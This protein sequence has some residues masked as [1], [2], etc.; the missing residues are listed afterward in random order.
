M[1]AKELKQK[2]LDFFRSKGHAIIPASSLIPENDPTALFINSGMHPLVPFLLGEKHPSGKRL[3]NFQKC[4]RTG[5]I[6]DV[7]DN[8]HLTFFEMLGNWSLGDYFKK[9][10]IA[11]SFEFLTSREWLNIPLERLVFTVFAGDNDVPRDEEAASVWRSLG[12]KDSQI[13]YLGREDNWWGPAGQTGPCGPDTEMF[14]DRGKPACSPSCGPGCSCGKYVEIWNDVFMQYYKKAD[15]AYEP[16]TQKNID[17]GMGVERTAAMLSGKE[18]VYEIDEFQEI[19]R[20]IEK[21]SGKLYLNHAR[22]F[23]IIADHLR[24]SVFI[25]GDQRGVVPSNV[26][27]GYILRRLIRRA[28]RHG[29]MLDLDKMFLSKLAD[30]VINQYGEDYPELILNKSR[31]LAELDQEEERFLL[32]LEKGLREFERIIRGL[33]VQKHISGEL[34]FELFSTYGFP[35]EMTIEL[36]SERG[37]TVDKKGF[38]EAYERHQELSRHGAEKKFKGGLADTSEQSKKYHTA[39]HLLQQALRIVLGNHVEQKGSN[40]TQ[41]RLRFDFPHPQ[42][43]TE[44]ELKKVED[45][46]NIQIQRRLPVQWEEMGVEEAKA[47]GAIGLFEERYGEKV[48]VYS[49]GDFSKEICGGPHVSNTE[50]LGRFKIIKEESSSAGIRRIKAIL[51]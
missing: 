34:I 46:V 5:D 24:A 44:E 4:I 49:I 47:K 10:A 36:A 17:T 9:E 18:S 22:S 28:V 48:K 39:T 33:T 41:E 35:F 32:T 1:T 43:M 31:V 11:W 50:D 13:F 42:K 12:V 37:L 15:G 19:F 8:T 16:L 51:E 40:I 2:Y 26:D 20:N 45:L 27:Q 25:L 38:Q 30:C 3:A 23:R 14:Y 6:E 7:G 29:K 21:I